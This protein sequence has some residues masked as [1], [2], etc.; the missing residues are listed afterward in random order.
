MSI[1]PKVTVHLPPLLALWKTKIWGNNQKLTSLLVL[2]LSLVP[3]PLFGEPA[4]VPVFLPDVFHADV[5]FQL[6]ELE[7]IVTV[8]MGLEVTLSSYKT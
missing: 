3:N 7:D 5:F 4:F 8:G 6:R 2:V 1:S